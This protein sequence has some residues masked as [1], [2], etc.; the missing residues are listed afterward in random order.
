MNIHIGKGE[1]GRS[2]CRD[3]PHVTNSVGQPLP[4]GNKI[5]GEGKQ[6]GFRKD[7]GEER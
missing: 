5:G 1:V 7:L 6:W 4:W 2:V 3:N